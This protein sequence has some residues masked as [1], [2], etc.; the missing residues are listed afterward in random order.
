MLTLLGASE[1]RRR[2]P[3]G[4]PVHAGLWVGNKTG[5]LA[6]LVHDSAVV[7]DHAYG[8]GYSLAIFTEGARS[9]AA[10]ER[11]CIRLSRAVYS[12]M[13]QTIAQPQIHAKAQAQESGR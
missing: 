5:T 2:I 6:A 3:A 7:L 11:L 8:V 9:E 1:R 13:R 4:L 12:A 10:G